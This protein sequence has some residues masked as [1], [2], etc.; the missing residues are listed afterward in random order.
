[1]CPSLD[2]CDEAALLR[3]ECDEEALLRL[4][5]PDPMPFSAFGFIE[6]LLVSK[7][8]TLMKFTKN[9]AKSACYS[10]S[11]HDGCHVLKLFRRSTNPILKKSLT[12]FL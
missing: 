1:M 11:Y 12:V 8:V 2:D 6:F 7:K 5:P 4:E 9:R 10:F 3:L